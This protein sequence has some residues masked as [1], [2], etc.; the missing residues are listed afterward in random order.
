MSNLQYGPRAGP[1]D[2]LAL[3]EGLC[4]VKHGRQVDPFG[5]M[6]RPRDGKS[7]KP[8]HPRANHQRDIGKVCCPIQKTKFGAVKLFKNTPRISVQGLGFQGSYPRTVR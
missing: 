4:K 1:M 7:G 5:T 2:A 6:A 3:S 8:K